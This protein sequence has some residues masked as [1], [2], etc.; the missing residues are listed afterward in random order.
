MQPQVQNA[1]GAAP[2]RIRAFFLFCSR[3]SQIVTSSKVP[4]GH[5]RNI[6][7][8]ICERFT[9]LASVMLESVKL[10]HA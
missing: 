7:K 5:H 3:W 6:S 1:L 2:K 10:F 4:F 9:D 8:N